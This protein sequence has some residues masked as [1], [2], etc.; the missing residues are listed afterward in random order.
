MVGWFEKG[1][2]SVVRHSNAEGSPRSRGTERADRERRG[3][4]RSDSYDNV[5]FIK[6]SIGDCFR[7]FCF[8]VFGALNAL[9]YR[10]HSS[11]HHEN[12]SVAWPVV[13]RTKLCAVLNRN[14]TRSAS[15][16]IDQATTTL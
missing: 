11:S 8:V 13:C 14:P 12:G 15:T 10:L 1:R 16:Y 7:P 5:I 9:Q 2:S 6:L 3:A 4:A